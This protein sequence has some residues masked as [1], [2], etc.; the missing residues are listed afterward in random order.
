MEK[1]ISLTNH[2]CSIGTIEMLTQELNQ[3]NLDFDP[4][5]FYLISTGM[6]EKNDEEIEALAQ[7]LDAQPP[8][9]KGHMYEN[10]EQE[11]ALPP[12]L[13][14]EVPRLEFK[15]L[16]SHLKYEFLGENET[17]PVIVSTYLEEEQLN[18]LLRVLKKHKKAIGWTISNI[19]EI[20]PS[21]CMYRFFWRIIANWWSN[22]KEGLTRT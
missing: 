10:L 21:I 1:Y 14:I 13:E 5:E 12:L 9:K 2:T 4:L 8:Y 15:P 3:V 18:K 7:Y 11:K 19:Q 16:P 20:N 22:C 6:Q 17:L